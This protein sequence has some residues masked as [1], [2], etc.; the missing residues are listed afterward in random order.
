MAH[1]EPICKDGFSFAGDS[2]F[3]EASNQS[4]HRRATLPELR[5]ILHPSDA[6]DLSIKDPTSHWWE[7]VNPQLR[8]STTYK[9][10]QGSVHPLR[11]ATVKNESGS[12]DAA[13]GRVE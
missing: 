13:V 5:A 10:W 9:V 11:T 2:L 12:E 1:A 3:V 7:Y 6:S 8:L 4:C